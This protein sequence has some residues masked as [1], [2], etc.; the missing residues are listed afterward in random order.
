MTF[1]RIQPYGPDAY[2]YWIDGI[3]KIVSYDKGE[4]FA[5]FIQNW[6]NNWGDH[7]SEPPDECP[8]FSAADKC[9]NTLA[10]A[11]QACKDHKEHYTPSPKIIKRAAEILTAIKIKAEKY[12]LAA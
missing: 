9:W 12:K 8:R 3:Y 2:T 10:A 7:V 1:T 11:K 4:Y 5:Y 6:A